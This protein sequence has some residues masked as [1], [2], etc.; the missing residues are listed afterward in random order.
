M[1][2][3]PNLVLVKIL[4]CSPVTGSAR[5]IHNRFEFPSFLSFLPPAYEVSR[6]LCFQRFCPS[7]HR[8]GGREGGGGGG[9]GVKIEKCSEC[10]GKPKKCIKIFLDYT[11]FDRGGGGGGPKPDF[12]QNFGRLYLLN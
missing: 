1:D 2:R 6:R 7:V 5:A 3:S 9:G 12:V 4:L 11:P 10:H 8:G